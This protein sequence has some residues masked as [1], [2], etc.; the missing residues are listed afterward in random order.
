[1]NELENKRVVVLGA[2]GFLGSKLSIQLASNDVDVY[3]FVARGLDYSFLLNNK[4][5]KCIEFELSS[6]MDEDFICV[7]NSDIIFN[8]AWV[9]VSAMYRNTVKA[10]IENI[11][12]CINVID[13]A[14]KYNIKRLIIPGSA[15]EVSCQGEI[16]DGNN[17]P[18]PS[19]MYSATKVGV[20]YIAE[21]YARQKKIDFIWTQVTSIYGPGRDDNNLISYA[22]KTLLK[23]E[24]PSFTGLEQRWDYLYIDDLIDAFVRIGLYGKAGKTY[25]VGSGESETLR[26]YVEIIRD[27]INPVL[28]LGI[29]ELPYKNAIIDNQVLDISQ[30]VQDTGFKPKYSFRDG[31]NSVIDYFRFS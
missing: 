30:L 11:P 22:I 27:I 23:G 31:I 3:A 16:I 13:F 10:Q 26:T 18:A 21:T 8:M 14:E 17:K 6:L 19:D 2:N 28:P 25:A 5:I 20:H 24:K 12:F 1:M 29:G 9:G 15:S 7:N 4:K